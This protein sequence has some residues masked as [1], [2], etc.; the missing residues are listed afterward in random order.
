MKICQQCGAVAQDTDRFC[1]MC[2]CSSFS[3]M[4]QQNQPVYAQQQY[5]QPVQQPAYTQTVQQ[6][7]F[8]QPVVPQANPVDMS[9]GNI[10][11]GIIGAVLFSLAGVLLYIIVYQIGFVAG[12]CGL[13]I[14]LLA[15][16]GYRFFAGIKHKTS[17]VGLITSVIVMVVMIFVAFYG[18]I[19]TSVAMEAV[20]YGFDFN[21]GLE[22][23]FELAPEVIEEGEVISDLIFSYVFGIVASISNIKSIMNTRKGQKM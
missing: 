19:V 4:Q 12:I 2:G 11:L 21:S 6:P 5:A 1:Q 16:F 3:E 9:N 17:M 23:G 22:L 10:P 20:N 13:A 18:A 7:V 8:A 15:N 14:F